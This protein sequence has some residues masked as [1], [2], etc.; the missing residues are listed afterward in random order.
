MSAF[1]AVASADGKAVLRTP[2]THTLKR[3]MKVNRSEGDVCA[4][5]VQRSVSILKRWGNLPS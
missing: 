5:L 3:T 2:C 1:A 4:N